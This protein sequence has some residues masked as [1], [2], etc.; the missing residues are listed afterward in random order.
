MYNVP[1]IALESNYF[2]MAVYFRLIFNI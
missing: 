2:P 1:E